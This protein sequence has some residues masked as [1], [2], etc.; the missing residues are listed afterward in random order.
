MKLAGSD[1][2]DA[3]SVLSVLRLIRLTRITRIFKLSKNG[4]SLQG[5]LV[6][7]TTLRKSAAALA[8]LFCFMLIFS[9]LFATLIYTAEGGKYDTYRRMYVRADGSD[10]PYESIP[11]AMWWTWVTMCTVGYGD[12]FPTTVGGKIIAV[13]TMLA[14]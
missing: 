14:G 9:I 11:V 5:L 6:L 1:G 12:A 4:G 7:G 2:G 13:F 3:L 10:T 8:M